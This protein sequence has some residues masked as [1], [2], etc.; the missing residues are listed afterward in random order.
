M[1]CKNLDEG[2]NLVSVMPKYDDLFGTDLKNK[3]LVARMINQRFS[4][5]KQIIKKEERKLPKG[6]SDPVMWSVVN[7]V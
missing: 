3:I 2:R 4:K 7:A 1:F 6:P 5:R